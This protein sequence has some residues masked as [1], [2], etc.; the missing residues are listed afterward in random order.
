[1]P[2]KVLNFYLNVWFSVHYFVRKS[3]SCQSQKDNPRPNWSPSKF[4]WFHKKFMHF[5][6]KNTRYTTIRIIRKLNTKKVFIHEKLC[7]YAISYAT[8]WKFMNFSAT[9]IFREIN[10]SE[11]RSSKWLFWQFPR[12]WIFI[13]V[14]FCTF[15]WMKFTTNQNSEHSKW[16]KCLF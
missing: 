12:L 11:F 2:K 7:N 15:T 9:Q 5:Y 6:K 4:I 10:Y 13:L 8:V 16:L 3:S 1:M 14:N